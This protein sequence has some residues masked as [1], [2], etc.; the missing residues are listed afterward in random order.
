MK[1]FFTGAIL[2]LGAVAAFAAPTDDCSRAIR[3]CTNQ[4][5]HLQ[6]S[7]ARATE[8]GDADR[9]ARLQESLNAMQRECGQKITQ[10]CG[11]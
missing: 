5:T 6:S 8:A 3:W 7:L 2:A 1:R 10:A 11:G 9:A 4:L